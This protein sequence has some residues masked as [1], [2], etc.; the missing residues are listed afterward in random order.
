MDT[1]HF[2]KLLFDLGSDLLPSAGA[3]IA[4]SGGADSMALLHGLHN[5]N[6]LRGCGWRLHVAHLD[7]GL[8]S[9]SRQTAEFVSR[10]ATDLEW[11]FSIDARDVRDL[12]RTTGTSVEEAGRN[13]RYE[14]LETVATQQRLQTVAVAHHAEDQAETVLHRIL[15]GTGM[16]GL[17]GIPRRR[18]IREGSDVEIVR[19]LLAMRRDDLR[20]YL[21][22]KKLA[23]MDDATNE[24]ASAAT[25]NR[26][27]H[28]LLPSIVKHINP[29]IVP[30]LVRLAEQA[31][32]SSR[33]LR[34]LAT[35]ALERISLDSPVDEMLLSASSLAALPKGL[36]TEVVVA[37][38]ARLGVARK[39]SGFERR[40]PMATLAT[41]ETQPS[42]IELAGGAWVERR[43][44]RLR[45]AGNTAP[46]SSQIAPSAFSE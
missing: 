2:H 10:T 4:V 3:V 45:F 35:E 34:Q 1:R 11:P 9:D 40:E 7:H 29:E 31:D 42:R 38:L 39:R 30:A 23:W 27:R 18:P 15:R 24:D 8:R 26:I 37:S 32:R 6:T 12:A 44:D 14:F 28:D 20:G 41:A 46:P 13:A 16:A 21:T 33:T 5:V 17:A 19:P 36:Q 22:Q 43:G 25:R